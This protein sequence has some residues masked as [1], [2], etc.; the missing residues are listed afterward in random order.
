MLLLLLLLLLCPL[1]L[2]LPLLDV[3]FDDLE[4]LGSSAV[5]GCVAVF[6]LVTSF[7]AASMSRWL[8]T[9]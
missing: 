1:L 7:M 9:T 2:P 4:G 6:F 5:I 3:V 8:I